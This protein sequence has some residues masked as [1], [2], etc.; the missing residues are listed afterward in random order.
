MDR[1]ITINNQDYNINN[2][3]INLITGKTQFELLNK[4]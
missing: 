1:Y 4:V 3:N 2:A